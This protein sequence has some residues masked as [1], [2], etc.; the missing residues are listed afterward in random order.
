MRTMM[1]AGEF[2]LFYGKVRSA[3][4]RCPVAPVLNW[5]P[6]ARLGSVLSEAPLGS[7]I[8]SAAAAPL[9][10]THPPTQR[11]RAFPGSAHFLT[12]GRGC[13]CPWETIGSPAMITR[14]LQPPSP[15]RDLFPEFLQTVT[16]QYTE[17]F[18]VTD[19][20]E[21]YNQILLAAQTNLQTVTQMS[22]D[23]F[24]CTL[25]GYQVRLYNKFVKEMQ[26][27]KI[28]KIDAMLQTCPYF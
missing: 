27:L 26:W 2:G 11:D 20:S 4:F 10:S 14:M 3:T 22:S 17:F 6:L 24:F 16:T 12:R 5:L 28:D 18:F 15:S 21:E 8:N 13:R 7:L 19:R 9:L 25:P 1:D 23:G